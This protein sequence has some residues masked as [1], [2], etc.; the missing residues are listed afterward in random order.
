MAPYDEDGRYSLLISTFGTLYPSLIDILTGV[1]TNGHN[2]KWKIDAFHFIKP[3]L[4]VTAPVTTGRA[5]FVDFH[6]EPL[7]TSRFQNDQ[8]N[9]A[10]LQQ[11]TFRLRDFEVTTDGKLDIPLFSQFTL[12]NDNLI[13]DSD[14][15]A[16][17]LN[18]VA[19]EIKYTVDK[20]ETGLGGF[21]RTIRAVKR[22]T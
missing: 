2:I 13:N 19:K 1:S 18:L 12:E 14:N 3:L 11:D 7:I 8:A 17:T 9:T 5:M 21:I 10:Y 6:E 20:P 15:G 22:L 16:N 4:S